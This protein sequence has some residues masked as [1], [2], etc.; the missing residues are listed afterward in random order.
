MRALIVL[1][2][3]LVGATIP[4][5]PTGAVDRFLRVDRRLLDCV[6]NNADYYLAPIG[7]PVL[8]VL[9]QCPPRAPPPT[10]R[11]RAFPL[12]PPV[13]DGVG[14]DT[15]DVFTLTRSQVKCLLND[16]AVRKRLIDPTQPDIYRIPL[17]FRC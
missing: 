12:L 3:G 14:R 16:K 8:V 2:T 17:N 5:G 6:L 7:D 1:M 15:D 11:R 4:T 9:K 13:S 10:S